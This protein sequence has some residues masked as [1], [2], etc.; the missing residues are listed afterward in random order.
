MMVQYG[1][2]KADKAGVICV[3]TAS[4]KGYGLYLKHGFQVVKDYGLDLRPY[5]VEVTARRRAMVRRPKL[6]SQN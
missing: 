5:G 6:S 4:P 2:D 3:L 1:C